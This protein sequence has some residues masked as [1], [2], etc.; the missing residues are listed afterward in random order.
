MAEVVKEIN[1]SGNS[2]VSDET[3]KIYGG[4]KIN[5][6]YNEQ[7]LNKILS[8]L[9]ATNFFKDVQIELK[10][11][12]L[13][14]NLVEYPV[15][16]E[17]IIVG[18]KNNKYKDQIK[19]LINSKEKD[20]YIENNIAN[21]VNTIKQ[22]YS[23]LGFNFAKVD[24]KI[25]K[26]DESNLDLVFEIKRGEVTK[27][28]KISFVG[29]KKIRTKRLKDIIASE[30]H[31]FWKVISRNTKFSENL[32]NMDIRLLE[33][34]YKSIGYYDVKIKSNSAEIKTEDKGVE[35]IYSIDAGSRYVIKKIIT[36]ADPVLNKDIF[37]PLNKDY[38]KTI[39]SYYSPFKIKK[40]LDKIDELIVNNNLQFIE[41]NVEEIIEKD[42]ITIKF[43]IF[44]GEK[45]LVERINILGN[46]ITNEAVI[47]SE[48]EIDEGDPFTNLSLDKSIS[49]IKSRNIF[50]EVNYK[51]S[52][53]SAKNL[54]LID[55]IVEEKPTGEVM[56]GAGI[57]TNGGSF[58]FTVKENN[59]LGEGKNVALDIEVDAESL[60]G[61]LNYT[62]PNYDFLGN[63]INYYLTS[64]TNDKP[65]QGYENTIYGVGLSTTFEQF[66]D[67]FT[68]IGLSATHDDLKTLDS[69]TD[70][71]KKQSGTFDEISANY[72]FNYDKRNRKFMPTDGS[73]IGFNQSLPVYADKSFIQNNF[74]SSTYKTLTE[75]IIGAGKLFVS[76]INGLGSDDVRLSKRRN[77]S[78]KRLR[79]F[80]KG[81]VGPMDGNDH[82]GGNYA[83]ALNFEANLPNLF[84]E[85]TNTDLGFFLDF[86][87]VW[88]V[89][90]D[91]TLDESSKIR[92]STGAV[93]N[94]NSPLGPMNFTF[95]TN[96]SKA[97]TDVT[98]SFNF[99][100][101]TTF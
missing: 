8:N 65:E 44:E 39:G 2:R 30:E 57:G 12:I 6:D 99:N 22:L 31:N 75:D 49:N 19:K 68:S 29:D 45:V 16:N 14:I 66:S 13:K 25:R 53:G 51:L 80:E 71:L 63:S 36:N 70:S 42:T 46:N 20:S 69:A 18:E 35:L 67:V 55:I 5:Q 56:A 64:S 24:T 98:E 87:N 9:F 37:F 84:P 90:Y 86:A 77:L 4:V 32:V 82:I 1:I 78:S 48:M 73:I 62:N 41:H 40:L 89:D 93:I 21:D 28:S 11:N 26:I 97:S 52:D 17:L 59:Y 91:S 43:N 85:S 7:D 3:I 50:K 95:A 60:Q 54:K 23:S 83:A 79:G 47:R 33:N 58:A 74:F 96:L 100:L 72:G 61:T 34:Y 94:W 38:Q 88:G 27:I 10:N 81:K 101:G 15:I 92:S 76:T